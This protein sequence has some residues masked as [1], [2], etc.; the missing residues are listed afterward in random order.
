MVLTVHRWFAAKSCPGNWMFARMGD[1][2]K[3]VTDK[4][5]GKPTTPSNSTPASKPTTPA[6]TNSNYPKVPFSVQVLVSDLNIR[7]TAN[8]EATGKYTGKG[9][10][11]IT[12][13][14]GDW[15]KL[16]SGAGWIYLK[17]G[18]YVSIGVGAA[19]TSK[20]PYKVRVSI[21]DLNIRA[22]AGTNLRQKV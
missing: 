4:L 18:E 10:F 19:T 6:A 12:Q 15:G 22:G 3:A 13:V 1:L 14:S 5:G 21:T 9:T 7:K 2:A 8:G 16:K 20:V 11:T 17:N